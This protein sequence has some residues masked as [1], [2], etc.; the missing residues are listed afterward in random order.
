M[1]KGLVTLIVRT[2]PRLHH[3]DNVNVLYIS[4]LIKKI[5]FEMVLAHKICKCLR[6]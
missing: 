5:W 3:V 2:V 1:F 6:T 4:L